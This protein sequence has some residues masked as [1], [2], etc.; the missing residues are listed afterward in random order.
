M[1]SC[2]GA[3]TCRPSSEPQNYNWGTFLIPSLITATGQRKGFFLTHRSASPGTNACNS[4]ACGKCPVPG[5]KACHLLYPLGTYRDNCPMYVAYRHSMSQRW[6]SS[7]LAGIC[8]PLH[9]SNC[10][11]YLEGWERVTSNQRTLSLPR[12]ER[13]GPQERE[14]RRS[15][16]TAGACTLALDRVQ[17]LNSQASDR[18]KRPE[19]DL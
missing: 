1:D 5:R 6:I 19:L 15:G 8:R 7:A 2:E 16:R 10:T 3:T 14:S 17:P 12:W 18:L 13:E 9:H 11:F 4:R